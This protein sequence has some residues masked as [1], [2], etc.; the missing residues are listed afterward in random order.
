MTE[1]FE[2]FLATVVPPSFVDVLREILDELAV[3]LGESPE[4]WRGACEL[5]RCEAQIV[6]SGLV[7]DAE[8]ARM[9]VM[10]G[11]LGA[12]LVKHPLAVAARSTTTT[13]P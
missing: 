1:H 5:A 9:L 7:A 11:L 12:L 8:P 10:N 6:K 2:E 13:P 4:A 3:T